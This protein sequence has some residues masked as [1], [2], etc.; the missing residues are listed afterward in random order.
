[1]PDLPPPIPNV[2]NSMRSS[3][4]LKLILIGILTIRLLILLSSFVVIK[5][6]RIAGMMWLKKLA[7]NGVGI[8]RFSV[9]FYLSHITRQ[10][11]IDKAMDGRRQHGRFN[12]CISSRKPEINASGSEMKYRG[13]FDVVYK[14][15]LRIGNFSIGLG[16]CSDRWNGNSQEKSHICIGIPDVRGIRGLLLFH[17]LAKSLINNQVTLR[18]Y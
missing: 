16:S 13:I 6:G 18:R 5:T 11:R 17:F 7:Q 14:S 10:L 2:R 8:R 15:V 12:I 3:L 1:M 4:T 9:Q